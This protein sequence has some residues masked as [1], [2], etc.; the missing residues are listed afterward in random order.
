M[1]IKSG[2]SEAFKAL[3]RRPF[4]KNLLAYLVLHVTNLLKLVIQTIEISN[5]FL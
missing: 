2:P 3:L 1:M 4:L 5:F